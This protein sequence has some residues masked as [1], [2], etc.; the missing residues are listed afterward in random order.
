M[1]CI[2]HGVAKNLTGLSDF[3]SLLPSY[4]ESTVKLL[5]K[6]PAENEH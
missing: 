3:H 5:Q 2:F 6:I 1:D 4:L